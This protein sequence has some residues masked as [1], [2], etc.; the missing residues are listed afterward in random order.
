MTTIT[1]FL[2]SNFVDSAQTEGNEV[3]IWVVGGT[4]ANK[5]KALKEY[6]I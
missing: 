2:H 5:L 4:R 3:P 6:L 1:N